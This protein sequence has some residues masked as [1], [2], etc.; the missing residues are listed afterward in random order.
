MPSDAL[1]LGCVVDGNQSCKF[2]VESVSEQVAETVAG[3]HVWRKGRH[4]LPLL[5][6]HR[7]TGVDTQ[8]PAFHLAIEGIHVNVKDHTTP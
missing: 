4:T 6:A 5:D 1:G 8:S 3:K 2:Q 7:L